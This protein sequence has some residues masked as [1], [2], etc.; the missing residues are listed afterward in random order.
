MP[1]HGVLAQGEPGQGPGN[2]RKAALGEQVE[3]LKEGVQADPSAQ[4]LGA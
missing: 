3:L 1:V 4:R 2:F